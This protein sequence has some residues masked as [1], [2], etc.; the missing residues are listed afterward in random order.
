MTEFIHRTRDG[1]ILKLSEL[2]DGHLARMV[3]LIDRRAEE[4]M[5][6]GDGS[7]DPDERWADILYGDE[8]RVRMGYRYYVREQERRKNLNDDS[9]MFAVED[10]I[11]AAKHHDS[12]A[13]EIEDLQSMLREAWRILDEKGRDDLITSLTAKEVLREGLRDDLKAESLA[14]TRLRRRS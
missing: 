6:I 12:Y 13:G 10:L 11:E 9:C 14:V 1:K 7:G 8:V 4:G 2:D 5:P 3:E